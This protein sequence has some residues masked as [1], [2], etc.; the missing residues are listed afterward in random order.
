MNKQDMRDRIDKILFDYDI[1]A[2]KPLVE[3]IQS[4]INLALQEQQEEII[5]K[6]EDNTVIVS[7]HSF[8]MT[9]QGKQFVGVVEMDKVISLIKES[10]TE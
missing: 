10:N 9:F 8:P 2:P 3:R 7:Q 1:D 6:I 4:E 5:K